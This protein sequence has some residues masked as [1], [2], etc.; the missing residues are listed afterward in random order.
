MEAQHV[1]DCVLDI[2]GRDADGAVL[3]IGMAAL[4]TR[5]LDPERLLLILLGKCYDAARKRRREQQGAPG[6]RRGFEDEFHVFAKT[7]IEHLV[8]LV[9]HDDAQSGDVETAAAQMVA[10]PAGRPDHDVGALS[11]LAL[12]A[13]RIHAADAGHDAAIGMF[14]KPGELALDLQGELARRR[15]DQRQWRAGRLEPLGV[16]EQI[17][18]HGQSIGNGLA[19]AGLGRNQEVAADG[20]VG[21]HGELDGGRLFVVALSQGAGER[22][23]CGRKGHEMGNL[24]WS[25]RR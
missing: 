11:Q 4:V 15:H 1:D 14:V 16:A 17:P 9:E 23:T 8:G 18:C 22:R 20:V 3:D 10:Q 19:R 21:Q 12:L 25:G 7:E 24:D 13:A 5:D 2:V 6:V